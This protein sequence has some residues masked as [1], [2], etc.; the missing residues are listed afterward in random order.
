MKRIVIICAVL[1]M[2]VS[3]H[4]PEDD[5]DVM[6]QIVFSAAPGTKATAGISETAI[7]HW[8]VMLFD[9]ENPLAWYYAVSDSGADIICEARNKRPYRAYAIANYAKDGLGAFDPSLIQSE[10]DL[11]N[12]VSALNGNSTE[13]LTMFGSVLLYQFPSG[14]TSIGI[15]RLCSKVSI[16]KITLDVTDVVYSDKQFILN[17]LYL[18]NVYCRSTLS[19]DDLLLY[20]SDE[21]WYNAM[22]WHGSG[23]IDALDAL[24]GDRGISASIPDGGSYNVMHSFYAYPNATTAGEDS[25]DATWNPRCTRLVIEAT[26]GN[27]RYYYPI[28]IPEMKRNHNYTVTE[29]VIHGPGSLDPEQDIPGVIDVTL[30]TTANSWDSEY[31]INE[32]S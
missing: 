25:R 28:T 8:A 20:G 11:L 13:A 4:K 3:C 18:T 5:G 14:R 6:R 10:D 7:S 27:K 1:L 17:A 16:M 31:Y 15:Y 2:S 26:F 24:L 29:A 23:S 22:G 12:T 30:S 9:M 19:Q 21:S 32:N